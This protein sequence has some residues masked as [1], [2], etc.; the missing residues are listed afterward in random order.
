[1]TRS[2]ACCRRW[3]DRREFSGRRAGVGKAVVGTGSMAPGATFSGRPLA[4]AQS[5]T[6]LA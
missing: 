4:R 6:K 1:M 3:V 2:K 5:I